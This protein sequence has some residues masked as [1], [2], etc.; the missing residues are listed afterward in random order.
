MGSKYAYIMGQNRKRCSYETYKHASTMGHASMHIDIMGQS[1]KQCSYVVMQLRNLQ[2]CIY[3]RPK[4]QA[5]QLRNLTNMH[6]CMR[7]MSSCVT[8]QLWNL[9]I[10]HLNKHTVQQACTA[11]L[12]CSCE[13]EQ[14]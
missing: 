6:I 9:L 7:H 12:P 1:H 2:S 8:M 14:A 11:M 4:Q 13:F 10:S 3:Y 5:M